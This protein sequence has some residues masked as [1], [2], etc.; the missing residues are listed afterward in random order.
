RFRLYRRAKAAVMSFCSRCVKLTTDGG[1]LVFR[2]FK[3]MGPPPGVYS[4]LELA[5][6]SQPVRWESTVTDQGKPAAD[7]SSLMA[8]SGL[9]QHLRQPWPIFWMNAGRVRLCGSSLALLSDR[10]ELAIE[11]L[12]GEENYEAD[13]AYSHFLSGEPL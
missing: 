3:S 7:G 2:G 5:R 1:R 8:L 13:P 12:Y 10:K 11:A 6:S 9:A 4:L